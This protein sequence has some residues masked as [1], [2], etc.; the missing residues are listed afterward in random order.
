MAG[1]G[2][3]RTPRRGLSGGARSFGRRLRRVG[4]GVLGDRRAAGRRRA[5]GPGHGPGEHSARCRKEDDRGGD[6]RG[7]PSPIVA[8]RVFRRSRSRQDS[9]RLGVGADGDRRGSRSQG[10]QQRCSVGRPLCRILPQGRRRQRGELRRRVGL[11]RL[12]RGRR[13]VPVHVDERNRVVRRERQRAGQHPEEDDAER[14]DVAR[15][16]GRLTCRLFR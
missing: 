3:R 9:G 8:R 16:H 4:M 11:Q 1:R 15:R 6:Q 12:D 5:A 14:V 13:L 7:S 2:G 10:R